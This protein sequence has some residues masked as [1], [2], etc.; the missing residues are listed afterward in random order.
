M[1][2]EMLFDLAGIFLL[3]FGLPV[4]IY[5]ITKWSIN[6]KFRKTDEARRERMEAGKDKL[7]DLFNENTEFCPKCWTHEYFWT[8]GGSWSPDR[9]PYH[10][11]SDDAILWKNMSRSQKKKAA[12][13]MDDGW[14]TKFGNHFF[15]EKQRKLY[16]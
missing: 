2:Y 1:N 5:L 16:E 11:N 6:R 10:R 4:A 8:G 13:K 12:R 15:N 9:C 14:Y 7:S 3:M